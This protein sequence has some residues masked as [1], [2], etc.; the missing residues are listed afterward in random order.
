MDRAAL[1]DHVDQAARTARPEFGS[2]FLAKL[3]DLDISYDEQE[4]SCAV[5]LPYSPMLHNPQGTVHGGILTMVLD[6]AMGHL[7]NRF[8]STAVTLDMNTRFFRPVTGDSH[9]EARILKQGRTI[10]H[11]ESRLHDAEGRLAAHATAT[12]HRLTATGQQ[13][14]AVPHV[15]G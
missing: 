2:F 12:W 13:N 14:P 4:Q 5:R 7:C 15:S 6:I 3:L 9:S 11:L 1:L 8:L 10:V